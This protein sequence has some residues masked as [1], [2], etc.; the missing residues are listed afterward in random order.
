[1]ATLL[2]TCKDDCAEVQSLFKAEIKDEIK[3]ENSLSSEKFGKNG[4]TEIKTLFK[5]EI[6]KELEME[7]DTQNDE[8]L[9]TSENASRSHYERVK[10]TVYENE[11]VID[12]LNNE[13]SIPNIIK[14]E[15]LD[16]KNQ[17]RKKNDYRKR[18]V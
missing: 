12:G 15:N 13:M 6:K 10:R 2:T 8:L 9:H 17:K 16:K 11:I 4:T 14:K 5:E 3:K 18:K 7:N 1:M